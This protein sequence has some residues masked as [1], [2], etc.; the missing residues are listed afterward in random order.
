MPARRTKRDGQGITSSYRAMP[1]KI[2]SL[3]TELQD[4]PD[5]EVGAELAAL[6]LHLGLGYAIAVGVRGKLSIEDP[7]AQGLAVGQDVLRLFSSA[8]SGRTQP[9]TRKRFA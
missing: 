1:P 2:L 6:L 5:W 8:G 4:S 3:I 7:A 9:K